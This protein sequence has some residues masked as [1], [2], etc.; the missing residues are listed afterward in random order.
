MSPLYWHC[1][2]HEREQR[3][4][5]IWQ[6][7]CLT[8]RASSQ[9]SHSVTPAQTGAET[10]RCNEGMRE[11]RVFPSYSRLSKL[12]EHL[13]ASN[14]KSEIADS[15]FSSVLH[16][17]LLTQERVDADNLHASLHTDTLQQWRDGHESCHSNILLAKLLQEM[18]NF[19]N[20]TTVHRVSHCPLTWI[21]CPWRI[22][23]QSWAL[24]IWRLDLQELI[25]LMSL[26]FLLC[27]F[28]TA[29]SQSKTWN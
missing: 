23:V 4:L 19:T 2:P 25:S 13:T 24:P 20:P 3:A 12:F 29:S 14:V 10:I 26:L 27:F 16:T 8:P 15:G 18:V 21:A 9:W 6:I 7:V 17:C 22:L 1:S 5:I 11:G 28:S